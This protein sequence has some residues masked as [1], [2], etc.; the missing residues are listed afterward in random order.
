MSP[1]FNQGSR[2]LATTAIAATPQSGG[3]P[4]GAQVPPASG[5]SAAPLPVVERVAAQG[6]NV[7]FSTAAMAMRGAGDAGSGAS[8]VDVARQFVRSFAASVVGEA[9]ALD[10]ASV[11]VDAPASTARVTDNR[12]VITTADGHSYDAELAVSFQASGESEAATSVETVMA[13][14]PL[15]AIEYPG[16]LNDLFKVL[17]RELAGDNDP[18]GR[19]SVRLMRLVD[20][21]ALLAPRVH[22]DEVAVTPAARKNAA[23]AY[24]SVTGAIEE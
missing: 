14:K 8:T 16:S 10:P 9:A 4:G 11:T 3:R 5:K 7:R 22:A 6:E 15:P 21:A 13:G 24:A 23:S 20:R 17:G 1:P 19:L 12:A 2:P 18:H